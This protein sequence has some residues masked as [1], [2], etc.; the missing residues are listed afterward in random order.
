MNPTSSFLLN[1]VTTNG[2]SNGNPGQRL[3]EGGFSIAARSDTTNSEPGAGDADRVVESADGPRESEAGDGVAEHCA[4]ENAEQVVAETGYETADVEGIAVEGE[5][6]SLADPAGPDDL[7]SAGSSTAESVV[8]TR[9]REFSEAFERFSHGVVPAL[10]VLGRRLEEAQIP[11]CEPGLLS[12]VRDLVHQFRQLRDKVANQQA[13][14]LI[15]G[16]LKSGKSTFMNAMCG[17]YVSEV[18]SLPAYP[19]M[20]H[21]S[22]VPEPESANT[23][24]LYNDQTVVI[25]DADHLREHIDEA[26]QQL[27]RTMREVESQGESFDP[28]THLPEAI[29]RVDVHLPA[30]QL[31]ESG[32]VLVDTPGLYTRM[33]FGYDRMT[34]D[35]RNAAA[36]A[37][38]IVKTD[39][40]FLEQVFEE[41]SEL[42]E[43]FSR[44][45]LVVNIDSSKRDL[46]PDG[47]L[48]P[49]LEHSDPERIVQAFRDLAMTAPLKAAADQGRLKIYPVDLLGAAGS[50]LSAAR[51]AAGLEDANTLVAPDAESEPV[52]PR[53]IRSTA[54]FDQLMTD[55]TDYLNSSEYLRE[56]LRDSL[57]RAGSLLDEAGRLGREDA[58]SRLEQYQ[59]KLEHQRSELRGKEE[60]VARLRKVEWAEACRPALEAM[61]AAFEEQGL[62]VRG[63][64]EKYIGTRLDGWFRGDESLHSLYE[65]VRS[66]VARATRCFADLFQEDSRRRLTLQPEAMHLPGAVS[67]AIHRAEIGW[68]LGTRHLF[69]RLPAGPTISEGF[70]A[71]DAREVPVRKGFWDWLLFRRQMVV[72]QRILGDFANPDEPIP[73]PIKARRLG[74]AGRSVLGQQLARVVSSTLIEVSQTFPQASARRFVESL[75]EWLNQT[76]T[77]EE[78]DLGRKLDELKPRISV[79]EQLMAAWM[80]MDERI[81]S[82]RS[83]LPSLE[84][85]F[86]AAPESSADGQPAIDDQA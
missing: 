46:A 47:S 74:Q 45:F 81:E 2:H 49:S 78:A 35:F 11:V 30:H 24:R 5:E 25:H 40:L 42:L 73:A 39:N 61:T 15:F 18:T 33:R 80:E 20:V 36:S 85:R 44:I 64:L 28:A 27:I 76:L 32:A 37:I 62:E 13:Y 63:S 8:R 71:M 41:F 7:Q 4:D 58:R 48:R 17:Q 52:E 86:A 43:L 56:F 84:R 3:S 50:R 70:E 22:H 57:W 72:Q 23:L 6:A 79:A 14:V 21:V 38:F 16:P 67:Q 65:S 26:H 10:E 34:R 29:R 54:D 75:A 9:L 66:E 69:S 51:E 82:A 68:Q 60:A 1:G 83:E 12:Q 77:S 19:C 59:A 53:T 55:L 31:A